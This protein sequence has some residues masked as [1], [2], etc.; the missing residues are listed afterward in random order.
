ME[1]TGD[2]AVTEWQQ[3]KYSDSKYSWYD[4]TVGLIC[5]T[6][7]K[8]VVVDCQNEPVTCCGVEYRLVSQVE[9]RPAGSNDDVYIRAKKN[10][11]GVR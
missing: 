4:C 2:S 8:T 3:V 1:Q 7:G 10:W 6:C 11:A 9:Q 5:P